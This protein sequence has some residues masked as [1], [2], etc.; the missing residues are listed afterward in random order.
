[1]EEENKKPFALRNENLPA[2]P[3]EF[4]YGDKDFT[5][6]PIIANKKYAGITKREYFISQALG[7]F[8]AKHGVV[9]FTELDADRIMK[10][11]DLMLKKCDNRKE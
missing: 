1:M 2:Y 3:T 8:I 7:G 5:G 6:M 4:S 10:S 9:D 11:V